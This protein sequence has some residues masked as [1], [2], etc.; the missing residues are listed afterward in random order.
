M[1]KS[2]QVAEYLLGLSEP[3]Y[4]DII[5]NL[6][7]QKLVYYAQGFHL[8]IY[9]NPLF[10]EPIV[11]WE[12][13]PVVE[14]LYHEYKKYGPNAIPVPGFVDTSIFSDEQ[15]ELL[16]EV[17]EV[18]GQF[19]AWKLRCM[20]HEEPPWKQAPLKGVIDLELMKKYFKTQLANG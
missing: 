15:K 6:K 4:G 17:F 18:Y 8:A 19:S 7:L 10:D 2:K 12:H 16:N 3:E 11:K 1:I 5:S 9:D 14:S 13:G 20:S